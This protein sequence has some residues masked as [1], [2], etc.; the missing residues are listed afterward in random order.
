[1]EKIKAYALQQMGLNTIEANLQLGHASDLRHY[2]NALQILL[3][4]CWKDIEL[5]SNNPDK[6]AY[7]EQAGLSVTMRNMESTVNVHND[8]YLNVKIQHM[9]HAKALLSKKDSK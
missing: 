3:K 4:K 6:K 8:G 9:G 2:G 7:L 1:V 5:L